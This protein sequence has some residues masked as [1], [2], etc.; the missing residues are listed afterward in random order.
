MPDDAYLESIRQLATARGLHMDYIGVSTNHAQL[1]QDR[2]DNID[3]LKKFIDVAKKMGIPMV[4][5]FGG[6]MR[7]G[8]EEEDIF[9]RIVGSIKECAEYAASQKILIGLHNHNHGQI[10]ATGEM[11]VRLLD[12]VDSPYFVG[13]LDSGQWYG[14]PGIG[15]GPQA[16]GKPE[17]K[18]G[19]PRGTLDPEY[20][21]EWVP[22]RLSLKKILA[23]TRAPPDLLADIQLN[24]QRYVGSS[25]RPGVDPD[26]GQ[27]GQTGPGPLQDIPD[28]LGQGGVVRR[29]WPPAAPV[30]CLYFPPRLSGGLVC[31]DAGAVQAGL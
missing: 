7:E 22:V 13:L 18:H 16:Y 15:E 10:P 27:L 8:D 1:G 29:L 4:R 9:G 5:T 14:S 6:W 21:C 31:G 30:L 23:P 28:Q 17:G 19:S 12:A 2:Q 3:N 26:R 24:S 25:C 20:D 11:V